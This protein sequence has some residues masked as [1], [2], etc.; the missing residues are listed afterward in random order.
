MVRGQRVREKAPDVQGPFLVPCHGHVRACRHDFLPSP[1]LMQNSHLFSPYPLFYC[2]GTL[3][4]RSPSGVPPSQDLERCT[5]SAAVAHGVVTTSM[6]PGE[7]GPAE[8]QRAARE[9]SNAVGAADGGSMPSKR[10]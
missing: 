5:I 2:S 1:G 3:M 7:S 6:Q 8:P 4:V 10:K 9:P